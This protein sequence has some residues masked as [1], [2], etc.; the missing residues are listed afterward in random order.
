MAAIVHRGPYKGYTIRKARKAHRCENAHA[1]K[2]GNPDAALCEVTIWP[3]RHYVE[4]ECD[5]YAAGGF[6]MSKLCMSCAGDE[7][8]MLV[9]YQADRRVKIADARSFGIA[10]DEFGRFD[11]HALLAA[12]RAQRE[13]T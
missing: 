5:P 1:H 7:V 9:D 3:G 10:V 8:A 6:G 13:A 11:R 4:T 12:Y 2:A